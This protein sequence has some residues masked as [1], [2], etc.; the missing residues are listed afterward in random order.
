V[1]EVAGNYDVSVGLAADDTPGEEEGPVVHFEHSP[2]VTEINPA[3][4]KQL[5]YII[6]PLFI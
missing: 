5:I 4:G 6:A 1:P 2:F 3:T